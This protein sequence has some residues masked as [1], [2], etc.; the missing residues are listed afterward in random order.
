MTSPQFMDEHGSVTRSYARLRCCAKSDSWWTSAV[1]AAPSDSDD[2]AACSAPAAAGSIAWQR[3][4]RRVPRRWQGGSSRGP[5]QAAGTA[6]LSGRATKVVPQA[7]CWFAD[8][9]AARG[10]HGA[11]RDFWQVVGDS[12]NIE[13]DADSMLV[14]VLITR[15]RLAVRLQVQRQTLVCTLERMCKT[16]TWPLLTRLPT[17]TTLNSIRSS[18]HRLSAVPKAAQT[19]V[20]HLVAHQIS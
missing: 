14:C 19:P 1:P 10:W 7:G 2:A 8:A 17:G 12:G 11:S 20:C 6:S 5:E 13:H 15:S 18:A 3:R 16:S 4:L 9:K